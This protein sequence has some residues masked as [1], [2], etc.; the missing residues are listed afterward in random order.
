MECM[1]FNH[2][3]QGITWRAI[4]VWG[5]KWLSIKL[6]TCRFLN[7]S[8]A[9]DSQNRYNNDNN[10]EINVNINNRRQSSQ[11]FSFDWNHNYYFLLSLVYIYRTVCNRRAVKLNICIFHYIQPV[12][13]IHLNVLHKCTICRWTLWR[14]IVEHIFWQRSSV[15]SVI[16]RD[17]LLLCVRDR[18]RPFTP[19]CLKRYYII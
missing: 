1:E 6:L 4:T 19:V 11:S 12:I 9:C 17:A 18:S 14:M 5:S 10:S 2:C 13:T 15:L 3:V 8:N 7:T 16:R